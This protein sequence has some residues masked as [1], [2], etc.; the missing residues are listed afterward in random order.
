MIDMIGRHLWTLRDCV[1]EG[2][3]LRSKSTLL[4]LPR[5]YDTH[6]VYLPHTT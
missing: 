4:S 1:R 5:Q 6:D 2:R 3:T